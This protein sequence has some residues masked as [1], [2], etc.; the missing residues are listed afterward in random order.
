MKKYLSAIVIILIVLPSISHNN[1]YKEK[2]TYSWWEYEINQTT[3]KQNLTAFNIYEDTEKITVKIIDDNP[4]EYKYSQINY[5]YTRDNFGRLLFYQ[6][7]KLGEFDTDIINQTYNYDLLTITEYRKFDGYS[8][9][10]RLIKERWYS[11][12][13]DFEYEIIN[14][15][16]KY[17]MIIHRE[18]IQGYREVNRT[19]DGIFQKFYH[20]ANGSYLGVT[21]DSNNKTTS[22]FYDEPFISYNGYRKIGGVYDYD[23]MNIVYQKSRLWNTKTQKPSINTID[24]FTILINF[25]Y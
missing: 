13:F 9:T 24:M 25:G 23:I 21:T 5:I 19:D 15:T 4:P 2:N 11:I 14:N 17:D 6:I 22:I 8:S 10:G 3:K 18:F 7:D 20:Y 16:M 1:T 12:P